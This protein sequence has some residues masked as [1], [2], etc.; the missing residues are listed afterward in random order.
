MDPIHDPVAASKL[1]RAIAEDVC[2]YNRTKLEGK[3]GLDASEAIAAEIA[4]GR[5]LYESRVQPEHWPLFGEAMNEAL[6]SPRPTKAAP[7]VAAV[8]ALFV[9][10]IAIA[11]YFLVGR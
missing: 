4:E 11:A 5:K 3:V 2:L 8:V 7:P 9:V 6:S 10:A 1:A